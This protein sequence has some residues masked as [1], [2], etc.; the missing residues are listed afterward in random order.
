M[1]E[2]VI[3]FLALALA[4]ALCV[5]IYRWIFIPKRSKPQRKSAKRIKNVSTKIGFRENQQALQNKIAIARL[6]GSIPFLRLSEQ[7][8]SE[9]RALIQAVDKRTESG[10]LLLPE[11]I[12]IRQLLIALGVFVIVLLAIIMLSPVAVLGLLAMPLAMQIPVKRLEAE[13]EEFAVALA[14]EF[15]EFYKLYYVQ[16]I[17]PNNTTTLSS[18]INSYLPSAS[19]EVKKILKVVDGDLAKGEEFALKRFD[20]RFPD[21][22]KVHKFC[23]VA[24]ARIKGDDSCY[25]TLRSFL[26]LLVEER[27]VFFEN[28]KNRRERRLETLVMMFLSISM[29]VVS[30]VIFVMMMM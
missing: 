6:F 21:S 27:D 2:F 1:N 26:A 7:N 29:V 24:R 10:R 9:I 16:F 23:S 3:I 11:E 8:K 28:E 17:R 18:V 12:Y 4:V 19:F 20:Q 22:P 14:D 13:R 5:I 25:E 15:L 30:C